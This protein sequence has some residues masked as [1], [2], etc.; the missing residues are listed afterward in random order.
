MH[1]RPH[2]SKFRTAIACRGRLETTYSQAHSQISS[3]NEYAYGG[4][5]PI[6]RRGL[7][8]AGR[9]QHHHGMLGSLNVDVDEIPPIVGRIEGRRRDE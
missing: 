4:D 5:E 1:P 3:R 7:S 9:R 8:L 6:L 2:I